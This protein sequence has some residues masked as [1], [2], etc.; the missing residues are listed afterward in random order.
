MDL[1]NAT[2]MQAAYTLGTD[3]TGRVHVVVAIKGT[4]AIPEDGGVCPLALDQV[5]LVDAD[6]STGRPG[7]S[8]PLYESDYAL[9]K[10][11]CDVI[12]NGSAYAPG[13]RPAER[14]PV[15]IRLGSW[16][17]TLV[18]V[19]D[20]TWQQKVLSTR[21]SDPEPF[22]VKPISYD[23]AFGG[24]DDLD[25]DDSSHDAYLMNPVGKG[26]YRRRNGRLIDGRPLCNTEAPEVPV[27]VPWDSYQP[28]SFGAV[29]RGWP[30]R[31]RF[32]GTYDQRWLGEVFPFLPRDFDPRYYQAA[33]EDQQVDYPQG[34][35]E[36]VLMG[37]TP[38]GQ[39][40]FRLPDS[41]VPVVFVRRGAEN[42]EQQA[43]LDTLVIEPDARRVML[44]WRASIA[45]RR[46]IFEVPQAVIGRMSKH[47]WRAREMG[48]A[49]YASL[50]ELVRQ[51]PI[52]ISN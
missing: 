49:Y 23:V 18:V 39:T 30:Q 6:Q 36:V 20:R 34:N 45:L 44:T 25:A 22:T 33:P 50:G 17:K 38:E 43:R 13:G 10:P 31:Y 16:F 27:T 7:Y 11:R 52:R 41:D 28:M 29:G 19:G 14:V 15:G 37:L 12:C 5:P 40:R 3:P 21:P 2:H 42:L 26:W 51:P 48:K 35:E 4:F 9:S 46:D 8:A 47:W 32:A 24:V 1:I